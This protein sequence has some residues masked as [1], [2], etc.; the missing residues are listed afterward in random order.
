MNPDNNAAAPYSDERVGLRSFCFVLSISVCLC[1]AKN[2]DAPCKNHTTVGRIF[3]LWS[4]FA[5]MTDFI[6]I[7]TRLVFINFTILFDR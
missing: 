6:E 3:N 5:E 7:T 2:D 4:L 1:D